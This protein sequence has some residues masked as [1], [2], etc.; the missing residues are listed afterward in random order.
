VLLLT[1]TSNVLAGGW[2]FYPQCGY[3]VRTVQ[4]TYAKKAAAVTPAQED[5][6]TRLL[7]IALERDRWVFKERQLALAGWADRRGNPQTP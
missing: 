5:W 4:T 6:R 2:Y 3:P 1:A 7:D